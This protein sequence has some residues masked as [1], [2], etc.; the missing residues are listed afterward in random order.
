METLYWAL[1]VLVLSGAGYLLGRRRGREVAILDVLGLV[2]PA[3]AEAVV[4]D[5]TFGLVA[6]TVVSPEGDLFY[7]GKSGG[8]ARRTIEA[9]RSAGTSWEAYRDGDA[10]DWGP[11]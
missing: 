5:G 6:F 1:A 2:P 7:Q 3:K 8:N 9:L 11:R 4:R 10:W